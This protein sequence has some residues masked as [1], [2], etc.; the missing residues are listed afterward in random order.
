M[1]YVGGG[2]AFLMNDV[3]NTPDKAHCEKVAIPDKNTQNLHLP[4][5]GLPVRKET[6]FSWK[7]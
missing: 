6:L 7:K 5:A 4:S 1:H 2:V 3:L